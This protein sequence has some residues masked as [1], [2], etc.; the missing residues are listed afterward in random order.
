MLCDTFFGISEA[1]KAGALGCIANNDLSDDAYYVV[2]FPAS[3]LNQD[4]YE[5]VLSYLNSTK[6]VLLLL[7]IPF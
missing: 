2:P 1:Y 4:D 6:Y 7:D 5:V 3:A